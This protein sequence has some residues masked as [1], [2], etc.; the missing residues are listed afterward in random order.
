MKDKRQAKTDL[1]KDT[2]LCHCI[3]FVNWLSGPTDFL[4]AATGGPGFLSRLT[5]SFRCN[6]N[7]QY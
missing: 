3:P 4:L 6:W 2:G 1:R 7:Q 5:E